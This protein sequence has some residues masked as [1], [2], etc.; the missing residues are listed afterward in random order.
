MPKPTK[1]NKPKK[2]A[3]GSKKQRAELKATGGWGD[4]S[5]A[6]QDEFEPA[7]EAPRW[8]VT[9]AIEDKNM[10]VK[11]RRFFHQKKDRLAARLSKPLFKPHQPKKKVKRSRVKVENQCEEEDEENDGNE[12]GRRKVL[13]IRKKKCNSDSEEEDN[14]DDEDRKKSMFQKLVEASKSLV[15]NE[16]EDEENDENDENDEEKDENEDDEEKEDD[17]ENYSEETIQ[18]RELL[19]QAFRNAYDDHFKANLENNNDASVDTLQNQRFQTING[20][21][22]SYIRNIAGN[23]G[24][25]NKNNILE[26]CG[27]KGNGPIGNASMLEVEKIIK[28][29]PSQVSSTTSPSIPFIPK[30][31]QSSLSQFGDVLFAASIP[32][33]T[34]TT[35]SSQTFP[36]PLGIAHEET[37][38]HIAQVLITSRSRVLEHDLK[39]K[40]KLND[41][42]NDEEKE[43]SNANSKKS[44]KSSSSAIN[45]TLLENASSQGDVPLQLNLLDNEENNEEEE[46]YRDQG[47]TRPR[48]LILC[49]TRNVAYHVF[50]SLK[51]KLLLNGKESNVVNVIDEDR[52]NHEFGP[53]EDDEDS[54]ASHLKKNQDWQQVFAGNM[55][56]NFKLGLQITPARFAKPKGKVKDI[57]NA[58]FLYE[59][60]INNTYIYHSKFTHVF[61]FPFF[62]FW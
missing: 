57:K 54:V 33:T 20:F 59:E 22:T 50:K 24:E 36:S 40:K 18:H 49:P 52:F 13:C 34:T 7:Q 9:Q 31:I 30:L 37:I 60:S 26:V 12:D 14:S 15:V 1:G 25:I 6:F 41:K 39:I 23:Q 51:N 10:R 28:D 43:I 32:P 17:V 11:E 48:V 53:D 29:F 19:Q 38:N 2:K 62:L 55:D 42:Q 44:T 3:K 8:R 21:E 46:A 35:S 45:S 47:F 16:E 58:S 4:T 27:L 5:T 61:F 56:D